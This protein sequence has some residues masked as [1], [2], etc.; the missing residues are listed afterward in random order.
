MK[1]KNLIRPAWNMKRLFTCNRCG[2]LFMAVKLM[3]PV[4][5]PKC[6]SF[7]VEEDKRVRY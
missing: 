5:C 3:L 6:G 2:H 4:K 7:R 1:P